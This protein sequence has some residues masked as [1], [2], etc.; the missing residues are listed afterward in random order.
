MPGLNEETLSNYRKLGIK[1]PFHLPVDVV[2]DFSV[3]VEEHFD[4]VAGA[5]VHQETAVLEVNVGQSHVAQKAWD[6][7]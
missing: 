3:N 5:D 7:D 1:V 2:N 6:F 4:F